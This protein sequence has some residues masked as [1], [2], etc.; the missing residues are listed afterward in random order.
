MKLRGICQIDSIV[1]GRICHLFI[2]VQCVC[3]MHHL[4][5]ISHFLLEKTPKE[6]CNLPKRTLL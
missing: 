4:I 6:A 3:Y 1:L 5:K 2:R